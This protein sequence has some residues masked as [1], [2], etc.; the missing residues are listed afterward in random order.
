MAHTKAKGTTKL[1]RDSESK[2]LGIKLSE[3]QQAIPGN[4]II[5]QRGSHYMPGPGTRIG[6]DDTIYAVKGGKIKFVTRKM[7]KYDGNS[8]IS[9]IVSII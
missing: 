9:K 7:K 3:S 2:R 5:R 1:G 4:I 6:K 8:K